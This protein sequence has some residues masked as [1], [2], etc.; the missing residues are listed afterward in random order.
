MKG[1]LMNWR[2]TQG[3]LITLLGTLRALMKRVNLKPINKF[4]SYKLKSKEAKRLSKNPIKAKDVKVDQVKL[5][6][7]ICHVKMVGKKRVMKRLRKQINHE[8]VKEKISCK[9]VK[10]KM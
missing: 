2:E 9:R 4:K 6:R 5:R 3:I 7:I 8:K 1:S 10:K